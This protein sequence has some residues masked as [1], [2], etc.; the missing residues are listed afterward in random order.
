LIHL[1]HSFFLL[2]TDA[3]IAYPFS[4]KKL[5]PCPPEVQAP[6]FMRGGRRV[7]MMSALVKEDQAILHLEEDPREQYIETFQEAV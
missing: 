1:I 5:K 4:E 2:R 3:C 6:N 7:D